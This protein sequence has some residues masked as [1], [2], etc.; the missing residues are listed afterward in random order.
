MNGFQEL[1]IQNGAQNVIV[2][3]GINQEEIKLKKCLKCKIE[4][5]INEFYKNKNSKDGLYAY[6]KS[7][8]YK[9]DYARKK[10][11]RL[12]NKEKLKL[13]HKEYN[14]KTFEKRKQYQLLNK[15]KIKQC[16]LK[17]YNLNKNNYIEKTKFFSLSKAKFS[18]YSD[19]ISYAENNYKGN[20]DELFCFCTY[21]GKSFIPTNA[22]IQAR[23][24]ALKGYTSGEG[25]LY[26]SEQCKI[27]CPIYGKAKYSKNQKVATSR[28]VS[29]EFRQIALKHFNY[30]CQ[31]CG[32]IENGLHVHH[33]DG[34]VEYPLFQE[35]IKNVI[36]V[37]KLC[38]KQIHS[39]PGCTYYEY[40]CNKK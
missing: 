24:G 3:T 18:T 27:E 8:C 25:R 34:I 31:R 2:H 10:V 13:K 15:D 36:V 14:D 38:H 40:R 1:T 21:C 5:I 33:I 30:T 28:E 4:K 22:Q 35:D 17:H 6:C 19:K 20:N 29:P 11:Y 7:C 9:N 37:C 26:C 12:N 32:S 23:I 16:K 39:K